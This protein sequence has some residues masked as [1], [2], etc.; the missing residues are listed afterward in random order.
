MVTFSAAIASKQRYLAR[1]SQLLSR[2]LSWAICGPLGHLAGGIYD[3]LMLLT[4]FAWAKARR[5]PLD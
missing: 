4:R 1:V 5:V 2:P 3:W